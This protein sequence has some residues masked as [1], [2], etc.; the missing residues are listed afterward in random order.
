MVCFAVIATKVFLVVI[1]VQLPSTIVDSLYHLL[2]FGAPIVIMIVCQ[3]LGYTGYTDGNGSCYF[4]L[5]PIGAESSGLVLLVVV[6]PFYTALA[7]GFLLL[8]STFVILL[9]RVGLKS[10]LKQSR[11]ALF[12]L[13]YGAC[14][15]FTLI[16]AMQSVTGKQVDKQINYFSCIIGNW[17]KSQLSRHP[18]VS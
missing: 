10:T 5:V 16:P 12:T 2:I 8:C 15:V 14:L 18:Q 4:A 6:V 13:V 1:R 7:W 9:Y 3:A 17:V 11:L